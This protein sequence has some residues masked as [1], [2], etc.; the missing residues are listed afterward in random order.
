ML[1]IRRS[2]VEGL[3]AVMHSHANVMESVEENRKHLGCYCRMLMEEWVCSSMS[4]LP[5]RGWLSA[6][7]A[8]GCA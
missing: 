8:S 3:S 4:D 5:R 2:G 6:V 7:F 1:E